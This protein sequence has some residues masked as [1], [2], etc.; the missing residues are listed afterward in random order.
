MEDVKEYAKWCSRR[1][2]KVL[3]GCWEDGPMKKKLDGERRGAL[4]SISEW[5]C[6]SLFRTC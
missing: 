5:C 3:G 1:H 2:R 4:C 6:L